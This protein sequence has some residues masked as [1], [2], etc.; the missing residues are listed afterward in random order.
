M[1]GDNG[2][3]QFCPGCNPDNV[4]QPGDFWGT[5]ANLYKQLCILAESL[6][7]DLV[8]FTKAYMTLYESGETKLLKRIKQDLR[9]GHIRN[10]NRF[11]EAFMKNYNNG[12]YKAINTLVETATNIYDK[13]CE[14]WEYIINA[15]IIGDP[16]TIRETQEYQQLARPY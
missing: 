13:E 4:Q 9:S 14:E 1:C 6:G 10:G 15:A 8:C 5:H 3:D 11:T 16:E 2:L 12:T 7:L